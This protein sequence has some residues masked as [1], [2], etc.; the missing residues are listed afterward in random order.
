MAGLLGITIIGA[1]LR[2]QQGSS[3]RAG[4]S[5][6]QAFLDGYHAGLWV[7]IGLLAAGVVVSYVSLRPRQRSEPGVL[8]V[9]GEEIEAEGVTANAP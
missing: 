9:P 5:A 2:A 7:T 6:P 1:V 3:L 4:A 8:A